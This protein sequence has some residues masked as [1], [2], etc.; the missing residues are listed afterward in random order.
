MSNMKIS[1]N[2]LM[3]DCYGLAREQKH[4][5]CWLDSS[6][7]LYLNSDT[8]G[9]LV[10]SEMFDYGIYNG[11]IVPYKVRTD[12]IQQNDLI[13]FLIYVIFNF[14]LFNLEI[15]NDDNFIKFIK[16]KKGTK[17]MIERQESLERCEYSLE[18]FLNIVKDVFK[19]KIIDEKTIK[20]V[21]KRIKDKSGELMERGD[22]KSGFSTTKFVNLLFDYIPNI[23]NYID[24]NI[25]DFQNPPEGKKVSFDIDLNK[26]TFI[27]LGVSITTDRDRGHATSFYKCNNKIFFYDNN[28]DINPVSKRRTIMLDDAN[29]VSFLTQ[30]LT[31]IKEFYGRYID[32]KDKK[33]IKI[34]RKVR[35][36][37][38]K[39]EYN[40]EIDLIELDNHSTLKDILKKY[41]LLTVEDIAMHYFNE[42]DQSKILKI[43]T[44]F[45]KYLNIQIPPL[46]DNPEIKREDD[47]SEKG[48]KA[49]YKY[50]KYKKKYLELLAVQ[51]AGGMG[52]ARNLFIQTLGSPKNKQLYDT[53]VENIKKDT[54]INIISTELEEIFSHI[55]DYLLKNHYNNNKFILDKNIDFI[56]YSYIYGT[57]GEINSLTNIDEF[58]TLIDDYNILESRK[59][60]TNKLDEI[61]KTGLIGL[62]EYINMNKEKLDEIKESVEKEKRWDMI[63]R[64]MVKE[65][66]MKPIFETDMVYIYSPE[67]ER[68]SQYYGQDTKWC[69]SGFEDNEFGNYRYMGPLYIIILKS[70]KKVKAQLHL[71]S[72][73]LMDVEDKPL[74]F[75]K[76][77]E[78]FNN[79]VKLLEWLDKK[80]KEYYLSLF[81]VH[82]I[83][84][85]EKLI[86]L[87]NNTYLY[88]SYPKTPE[89]EDLVLEYYR[90]LPPELLPENISLDSSDET[91]I[92]FQKISRNVLHNIKYVD[93]TNAANNI[94]DL[95]QNKKYI[96]AH[97]SLKKEL[98]KFTTIYS[99]LPNLV[100]LSLHRFYF[101]FTVSRADFNRVYGT[102]LIKLFDTISHLKNFC[103]LRFLENIPQDTINTINH[104]FKIVI[105]YDE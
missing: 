33:L 16:K 93:Y 21:K 105:G 42:D 49:L 76:M 29:E 8:L 17:I 99:F 25:I 91:L 95:A 90:K 69:T 59:Q 26:E 60:N 64:E 47:H 71:E 44:L 19:T 70:N 74:T 100:D 54:K 40:K 83:G 22:E 43:G 85:I 72:Q 13:S 103:T 10:R 36:F 12:I 30:K 78:L 65:G 86:T 98:L 35:L 82:Q 14:I 104:N 102:T 66:P 28:N 80:Y 58:K 68:Q 4:G 41:F 48:K 97:D 18:E 63:R 79:D 3:K 11:K 15:T 67:T 56:I 2:I 39:A 27:G 6:L 94:I 96:E 75:T 73:S 55:Y 81:K 23:K 1:S 57:F 88:D 92:L 7:E 24:L 31:Y 52:T 32:L 38:K 37:K 53:F 34:F 87:S 101:L 9:E 62:K 45:C 77:I 51:N 50:L 61:K 5:T 20:A 46:T 84:K 89:L